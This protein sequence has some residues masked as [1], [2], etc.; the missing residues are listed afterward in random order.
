M[1]EQTQ[2]HVRVGF[3][4]EDEHVVFFVEDNGMGIKKEDYDRIFQLFVKLDERSEGSG[5]GL[6][7][8]KRILDGNRGRIWV[9]SEGPGHGSRFCFTLADGGNCS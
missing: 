4:K 7:M 2:P 5:I 8:L 6:A 1:G 9:E 3:R